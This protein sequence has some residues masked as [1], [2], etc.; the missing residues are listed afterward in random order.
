ME[1]SGNIT[2][3]KNKLMHNGHTRVRRGH[4]VVIGFNEKKY[5]IIVDEDKRFQGFYSGD[6]DEVELPTG[7]SFKYW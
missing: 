4:L 7:W 6:I 5:Y 2:D 3:N 1:R